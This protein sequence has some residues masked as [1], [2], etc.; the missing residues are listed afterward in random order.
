MK[1]YVAGPMTGWPD[2]NFPE[3]LKVSDLL[4]KAGFEV[5]NPA[6]LEMEMA[7][8]ERLWNDCLKRDI[9]EVVN[10]NGIAVLNNWWKS[11]GARLEVHI[12]TELE[13]MVEPWDVWM[14]LGPENAALQ[15]RQPPGATLPP[16]RQG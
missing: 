8:E 16:P 9:I 1:L 3:F 10:C 14:A 2:F 15:R 11:R 5:V 7:V 4:R 6:E 12:A 13:L